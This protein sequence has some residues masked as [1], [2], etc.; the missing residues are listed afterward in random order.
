MEKKLVSDGHMAVTQQ[1]L[2]TA[3]ISINNRTVMP[4]NFQ[5]QKHKGT[6]ASNLSKNNLQKHALSISLLLE[7]LYGRKDDNGG[8]SNLRLSE[9]WQKDDALKKK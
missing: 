7:M 9:A 3:F 1:V 8:D 6:T 2:A 4:E 5:G